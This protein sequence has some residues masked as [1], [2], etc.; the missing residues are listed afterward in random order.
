MSTGANPERQAPTRWSR[1]AFG[2]GAGIAGVAIFAVGAT[3]PWVAAAV[4]ILLL[5]SLVVLCCGC[6]L[7][8][9]LLPWHPLLWPALGFGVLVIAQIGLGWSVAP[10]ATWTGLGELAGPAVELYLALF[11]FRSS[12][13]LRQL[14]W[15][16][17]WSVL[18]LALE[19]I[20]QSFLANGFIYWV[21]NATYAT[22]VGP[23]VYHNH[24]A[25]CMD[26]LIPL[27]LAAV[28][29]PLR[30]AQ[31]R[32]QK[33]WLLAIS[34]ALGLLAVV[35]SRS[36][37]GMLCLL[38]EGILALLILWR[39]G[40]M[41]VKRIVLSAVAIVG[42]VSLAN[43]GKVWRHFLALQQGDVSALERIHME[44]SCLAI[45]HAFPWRGS[46]FN[47]F[48]Q[49]YPQFQ[50]VDFGKVVNYAHNEYAQML[51]E[52]GVAGAAAVI[53]FVVI[54]IVCYRR[55]RSHEVTALVRRAALVGLAGFLAHSAIDFQF[56]SP[57]NAALFF[58]VAG[59][60]AAQSLG[61]EHNEAAR[62]GRVRRRQSRRG[63]TTADGYA[64]A[65][66]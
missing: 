37:G 33:R 3:D 2:A 28:F 66:G 59:A 16:A 41:N 31:G 25:G 22:P 14:A 62:S 51:A 61:G 56:H 64:A 49:V 26:L 42:L 46:G 17:W 9:E 36:R 47:T 38:G 19:A 65:A 29:L 55:R 4:T 27:S 40:K 57:A 5:I 52:M 18:L 44:Q 23:Y 11:A 1:F 30:S 20:P 39:T 34:P 35:I 7:T 6:S 12:R 45:W 21:R 58:L 53:A 13:Q 54:G 24:F 8:G 48:A 50:V 63:R 60:A 15:F 10:A 43:I 32:V